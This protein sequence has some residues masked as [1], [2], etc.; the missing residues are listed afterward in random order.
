[1]HT[2]DKPA[3]RPGNQITNA[4]GVT[5]RRFLQLTAAS[6]AV[7]GVLAA[8]RTP[9]PPAG[10]A[11]TAAAAS[12]RSV[13][14]R[15]GGTLTYAHASDLFS[16]DP[17]HLSTGNYPMLYQLYNTLIRLD[18]KQQPHPELAASWAL[19]PD[20]LSMNLTLRP[21]VRFHDG[22]ELIADDVL[23]TV[24]HYQDPKNTAT[25][26]GLTL[27][28]AHATATDRHTVKLE[29]ARPAPAIFDLLDQIF[30][31]QH[32]ATAA[33]KTKPVGTGPFRLAAWQPGD[34]ARFERFPDYWKPGLPLLDAVIVK[35]IPDAQSMALNLVA[36]SVDVA[37]Q[38]A[39]SELQRIRENGALEVLTYADG[40]TV[41]DLL[42]NVKQ[43]PFDN[44]LVR[45]AMNFA[46]DRQRFVGIYTGGAGQPW[47][48]PVPKISLAYVPELEQSSS[49]DL[50]KAR[51]LLA[52][53]GYASG[54]SATMVTSSGG[55]LPG[56]L[57]LAQILQADL[58]K[59]GIRLT[60]SDLEE[61]VARPKL[62]NGDFQIA[63]H[64]YGRSNRDPSSVFEGT[65]AW[66]PDTNA[67]RFSSKAYT[68]LLAEGSAALNGD[69]R[70]RIYRD[71]ARL[72]V[73][74]AFA[75]PV[76]GVPRTFG[77]RRNV[78]DFGWNL[79]GFAKL[80]ATWLE[81]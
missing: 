18:D 39:F 43:P 40:A 51:T 14:P 61:S 53:A 65:L 58:T 76:A 34:Q 49:F 48:L 74:E 15:R 5:R 68:D 1:M 20:G 23:A 33:L 29:F 54:F 66:R 17:S 21:G 60:I 56:S 46:V 75:L 73:D 24:Q 13:G 25:I 11:A 47:R 67:S 4:P 2:M 16:F 59:I 81:G 52:Q 36:G 69:D 26:R 7:G 72:V 42:L 41:Q 80:E 30:I 28:I 31:I 63:G 44:K 55:F 77:I 57:E 35:P 3:D 12:P 32:N 37:E 8:C 70:R 71:V 79:D 19:A 38:P 10:S 64:F 50:D 6:A 27:V 45:Q 9:S 62:V 22:Q 78:R